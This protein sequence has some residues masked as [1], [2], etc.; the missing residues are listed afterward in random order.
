MTRDITF[1]EQDFYEDI[2]QQIKPHDEKLWK[3]WEEF[4][5]EVYGI[6]PNDACI[7]PQ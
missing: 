3:E 2:I 6:K 1:L 7:L 5:T 4:C